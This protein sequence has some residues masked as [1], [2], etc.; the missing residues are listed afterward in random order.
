MNASIYI[1]KRSK[2]GKSDDWDLRTGQRFPIGNRSHFAVPG[3]RRRKSIS[4]VKK[5]CASRRS[6]DRRGGGGGGGGV[7]R[8]KEKEEEEEGD[9]VGKDRRVE[10]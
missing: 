1:R 8:K 5:E 6:P 3:E 7:G 9:E 4:R 2:S 10:K